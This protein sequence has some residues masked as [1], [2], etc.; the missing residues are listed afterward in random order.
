MKQYLVDTFKFND[1]ANKTMLDKIKTMPKP[2][3]AV[4]L[5]SHLINSQNKWMARINKSPDET[6]I[7]WFELVYDMSKLEFIWAES[8]STW[9]EFLDKASDEELADEL[10]YTASD[11][12]KL[13][14]MIKDI[15]LQLNY[16][17]IHHRAQICTLLRK[18]NIEPPFIEYIGT[19]VK[20]Y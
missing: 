13:G 4:R 15:A 6:Q 12:T 11:G 3:E 17:S 14:A 1:W 5:F 8:L 18:Q 9:L 19:V 10:H 20:R 16:H 2:E 7:S